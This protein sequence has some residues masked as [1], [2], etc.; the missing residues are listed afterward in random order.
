MD[1]VLFFF[2]LEYAGELHIFVLRGEIVVPGTWSPPNMGTKYEGLTGLHG[3][4]AF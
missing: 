1:N 3:Q 2:F 4:R